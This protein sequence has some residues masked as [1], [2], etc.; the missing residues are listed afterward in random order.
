MKETFTLKD[1]EVGMVVICDYD[2]YLVV[3][4]EEMD[5]L[6]LVSERGFQ[7]L[8]GNYNEDLTA[9]RE[10]FN[11]VESVAAFMDIKQVYSRT[12]RLGRGMFHSLP[13]RKLLYDRD[14][15]VE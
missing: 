14:W 8:A 13:E 7:P 4:N 11:G 12:N 10:L 2:T 6:L 5:G 3:P 9:K 15:I 1:I